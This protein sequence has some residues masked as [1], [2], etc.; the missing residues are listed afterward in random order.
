MT[1]CTQCSGAKGTQGLEDP[2]QES[3]GGASVIAGVGAIPCS[4]CN[5]TGILNSFGV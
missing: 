2:I 5:G 1:I 4:A 3:T